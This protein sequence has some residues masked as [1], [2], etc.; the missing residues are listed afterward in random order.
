[1]SDSEQKIIDNNNYDSDSDNE[2]PEDLEIK[3]DKIVRLVE[4]FDA[5]K[6]NHII[7]NKKKFVKLMKKRS[8]ERLKNPFV[9]M[10]KYLE[11]SKNGSI[12][13]TY[14]QNKSYGRF[15]AVGS[16]SLQL[17][18]REVRHSIQ[19]DYIDIDI[20]NAHPVILRYICGKRKIKCKH[21]NNYIE[22]REALLS[23]LK[24]D[25]EVG[26][27]AVLS[28]LNGGSKDYKSLEYRPEWIVKLKKEC[29]KIHREFKVDKRYKLHKQSRIENNKTFNH[30]GSYMNTILCDFENNILQSIYQFFGSPKNCV[31][32][33]DGLMVKKG[34]YDL[35]TCENKVKEDIG[36]DIALKIKSME[37]G[38]DESLFANMVNY[39]A[40]EYY[41]TDVVDFAKRS[42]IDI[43][44]LVVT[45]K[46]SCIMVTNRGIS[47]LFTKNLE[48]DGSVSYTAL[49]NTSIMDFEW[50]VTGDKG[51]PVR[52][53]VN[54]IF[55]QRVKWQNA[56]DYFNFIPYLTREQEYKIS[57]R[58]F[59]TFSGYRWPFTK[60]TYELDSEGIPI[61]PD[62]I[63]PWIYHI[64]NVLVKPGQGP[65]NLGTTVV[66]WFAHIFQDPTTKPWALIFRSEEGLGKGLWQT[67]FEQVLTK[68]YTCVF[69]SWDEITA[70]FNG[71]MDGKL[72]FTLNEATNYPTNAQKE[73]LKTLIKDKDLEINKKFVNQYSIHNY[74]RVW[75][76][77]QNPQPAV[78]PHDCR[79]YCPI[80]CDNSKRGNEEYFKYLIETVDDE[81]V[82]HDMFDYM[83][84]LSLV[85][86]NS[87]K[88]PMTNW[89]KELIGRCSSAS[90]AFLKNYIEKMIF[91]NVKIASKDLY[92]EFSGWCKDG[93]EYK[94]ISARNFYSELKDMGIEKKK[95][96]ID[97]LNTQGFEI[98]KVALQAIIDKYNPS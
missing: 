25:R 91:D 67:F 72:L 60:K 7:N 41:Y 53:S 14:K 45:L 13:V 3:Q 44:E 20:V 5:C 93:G 61:P 48:V 24:V 4:H 35:K 65:A 69:K 1:M 59:N 62:S 29:E 8:L 47:V 15:F 77:T 81:Q 76:T 46:G 9:V 37:E 43:E 21:L 52:Y 31:W 82:Q 28:F 63:K 75:A 6:L 38:F 98:E 17:L 88:P 84:N 90:V 73:I 19:Q 51:K 23:E 18:P 40:K 97:E 58:I 86:F 26:K 32:C 39:K 54:K 10:S 33:F 68:A 78:I 87:E 95:M 66:Q 16:L 70:D 22:N 50:T 27:Q 42:F 96:R 36:I 71:K 74:A 94:I 12:D 11:N 79:R 83:T 80:E 2:E 34:E 49:P 64:K 30:I 89:K 55:E 85:G 56:W 92:C 57:P